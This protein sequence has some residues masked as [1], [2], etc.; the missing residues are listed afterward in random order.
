MANGAQYETQPPRPLD[1]LG[2]T[3]EQAAQRANVPVSWIRQVV[4]DGRLPS[5]KLGHYRRIKP[6]DLERFVEDNRSR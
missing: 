3:V 4:K 1:K 2:L 5:L 6:A